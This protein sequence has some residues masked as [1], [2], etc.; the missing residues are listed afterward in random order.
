MS[1]KYTVKEALGDL[2]NL[3]RIRLKVDPKNI[4]L[5]DFSQYNGYEGYI[6]EE[7]DDDTI[8][9]FI[10]SDNTSEMQDGLIATIPSGCVDVM[11]SLTV[12]EKFKMAL[13]MYF[14]SRHMIPTEMLRELVL[15]KTI[16]ECRCCLDQ[17]DSEG[18]EIVL[19]SFLDMLEGCE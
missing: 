10:T 14:K 7:N 15:A 1:F 6:I 9:V 17:L 8:D 19:T 11:G 2:N 3:K 18:F 12:L 5:K 13:I 16:K 4:H